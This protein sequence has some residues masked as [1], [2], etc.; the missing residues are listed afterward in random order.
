MREKSQSNDAQL[1]L[2]QQKTEKKCERR[3]TGDIKF[4]NDNKKKSGTKRIYDTYG[5]GIYQILTT[6]REH[7]DTIQ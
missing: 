3:L 1:E 6:S 7:E 2:E 4:Q 5:T